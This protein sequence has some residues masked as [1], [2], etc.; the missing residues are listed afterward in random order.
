[1]QEQ[2]YQYYG[3]VRIIKDNYPGVLKQMDFLKSKAV[4]G[5]FHWDI[6]DHEA[7]DP[8]AEAF[9][10]ACFYYHHALLAARFAG[11]VDKPEDSLRFAQLSEDIKR[12]I[13]NKYL[14]PNT[15]R[16]DNGTQAAQIFALWY[17]LTPEKE[18]TL[19]ALMSE[20][21]RHN[22]HLSTGIFSTRMMFDLMRR[23]QMN[24][25]AYSLANAEG[26][27][28]WR[29]MLDNGAT[30][31]WETWK[32][33]EKYPS[34][35]HPMFGS[36]SEWFFTS[37]LG[38]NAGSPGYK[39]IILKPQPAGDL[40]WARGSYD[41][42]HGKIT[43]DWNIRDGKFS[44]TI[45]IPANTSASVYI[46]VKGDSAILVDGKKADTA[47]IEKGFARVELGSGN[48]SISSNYTQQ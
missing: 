29:H 39:K 30:T 36:V 25:V 14:V 22:G 21:E 28:G 31:L 42:V 34:Q 26:F 4:D 44:W 32:Y 20:I 46:P 1:L 17:D 13:V 19:N 48:Y 43:S 8:R 18:N 10:A 40:T 5:L 45:S 38:I 16:F 3:D 35:N 41:S 27:P 37:I 9:S 12:A 33:P 2:L 7:L 15:G 47:S 23:E 11:I 6:G 24:E